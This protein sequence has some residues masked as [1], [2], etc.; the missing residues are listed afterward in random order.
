MAGQ[1]Y[2]MARMK[3]LERGLYEGEYVRAERVG[4]GYAAEVMLRDCGAVLG[5]H[6]NIHEFCTEGHWTRIGSYARLRDIET[7]AGRLRAGTHVYRGTYT[8]SVGLRPGQVVPF[9]EVTER[10]GELLASA[11]DSPVLAAAAF[12]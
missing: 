6:T 1:Q 7:L 5:I 12:R 9:K 2:G 10:L 11:E 8:D 3:C 4:D